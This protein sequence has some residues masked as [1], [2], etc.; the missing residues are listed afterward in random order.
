MRHAGRND[1]KWACAQAFTACVR[2]DI[3]ALSTSPIEANLAASWKQ[4][5]NRRLEAHKHRKGGA[6]VEPETHAAS[7]IASSQAAQ[8]AAAR[9]AARYAKA[10]SYSQMLAE[11]ARSAVRAA[12][13]A[14]RAALDLQAA[15]ESVL[16]GLEAA[17]AAERARV[18]DS[19]RV[20]SSERAF[21]MAW[22]TQAE[23]PRAGESPRAAESLTA[24]TLAPAPVQIEQQEPRSYGIRW[25]E[26]LPMRPAEP[27]IARTSHQPSEFDHV[28]EGWWEREAQSTQEEE[29][30]QAVEPLQPIHA[31]LIEFPRELVATRKMRPRRAEGH[32]AVGPSDGQLSIF[33]VDPGSISTEPEP[34][35]AVV[36]TEAPVWRGAEWSDIRLGEQPM[37]EPRS[38]VE[39]EE[40]VASATPMLELAP[41]GFRMM[42][43]V[44]DGALITGA[45]LA[46][47]M[48]AATHVSQLPP[49][50]GIEIGSALALAGI[51][52]LYHALFL[53]LAE[54]TPG[55]K[56]AHI[57]LC[58]F[59]GDNPTAPQRRK[60]LVAMILSLLPV[61]LGAAWAIFDED[62]LTWHDRLSGTYLRRY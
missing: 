26:D 61:G 23:P 56:Y 57:A 14:S 17:S 37:V 2:R 60:R 48:V 46:A 52:A 54:G 59:D 28:V 3:G 19:F 9:V 39:R 44:V 5:V 31:N 34:A 6:A 32:Y 33:E 25:D 51:A 8:S 38:E 43:L 1:G 42:A 21:E 36:E 27:V 40:D 49:L 55:M 30:I 50:R 4:E 11:E 62:H 12:E 41:F 35:E 16:A 10:P 15:A 47:A 24:A 7:H 13:A 22:E 45:F 58:T 53:I 29:V 20:V 18:P